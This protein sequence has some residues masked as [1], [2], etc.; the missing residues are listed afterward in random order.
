MW[1]S[2]CS[3]PACACLVAGSRYLIVYKLE[4]HAYRRRDFHV[5]G[6][7]CFR[8]GSFIGHRHCY[9]SPAEHG[10]WRSNIG[11]RIYLYSRAKFQ[12]KRC[13][14][15]GCGLLCVERGFVQ[16]VTI[17]VTTIAAV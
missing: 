8:G 1:V 2:E 14:E 10:N 6:I 11:T 9:L 15:P 16:R 4:Y 7:V 12:V 3:L 5:S 13:G 17:G